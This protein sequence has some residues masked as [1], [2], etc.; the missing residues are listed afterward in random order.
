MT[1]SIFNSSTE[2]KGKFSCHHVFAFTVA[3]LAQELVFS[4]KRFCVI[5]IFCPFCLRPQRYRQLQWPGFVP[6][7]WT[8][9][10]DTTK[11]NNKPNRK[12]RAALTP[13][14]VQGLRGGCG[15]SHGIAGDSFF[16]HG[17]GGQAEGHWRTSMFI[18]PFVFG[19]A[20]SCTCH[21]SAAQRI[22]FGWTGGIAF[23]LGLV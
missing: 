3:I 18:L 19:L 1:Y 6:W 20:A 14:E 7:K 22:F 12:Q 23:D 17:C 15:A 8:S 13:R 2:N 9:S 4:L 5:W 10:M 16:L 11:Q 21:P